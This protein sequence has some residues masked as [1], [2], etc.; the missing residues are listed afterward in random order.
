MG[1]VRD[2]EPRCPARER[3]DA[4]ARRIFH[5][6]LG[7][8]TDADRHRLH[9]CLGRLSRADARHISRAQTE[10]RRARLDQN[11]RHDRAEPRTTMKPA[12]I[13]IVL[14]VAIIWGLAFVASRIALDEFSPELM[15]A[16]RFSI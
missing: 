4:Y 16:M 7:H 15:T 5:L 10:G 2:Q 3:G 13:I 1:R 14:L 8:G 11:N 12:D 6:R 9:A